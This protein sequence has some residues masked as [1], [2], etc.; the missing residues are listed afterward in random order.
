MLT[1]CL[2]AAASPGQGR[3]E[4]AEETAAPSLQLL[5]RGLLTTG[6]E[7]KQLG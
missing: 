1:A 2:R 7:A 3:E 6:P 4:E 5:P